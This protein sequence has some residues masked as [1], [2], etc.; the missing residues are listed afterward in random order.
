MNTLIE[1][2]N[3][4]IWSPFLV[5]LC[6]GAGLYFTIAGSS[7]FRVRSGVKKT[8]VGSAGHHNI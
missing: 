6:L 1:T 4:I 7:V 8:T 2:L 3:S 5:F